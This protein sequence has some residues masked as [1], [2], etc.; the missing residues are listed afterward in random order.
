MIPLITRDKE[1]GDPGFI[2]YLDRCMKIAK[3]LELGTELV[4]IGPD[5]HK[6]SDWSPIPH[7][8]VVMVIGHIPCKHAVTC[9]FPDGTIVGMNVP[10]LAWPEGVLP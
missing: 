8:S 10:N 3:S 6:F 1:P 4:Y 2:E 9:R 5:T 7:G